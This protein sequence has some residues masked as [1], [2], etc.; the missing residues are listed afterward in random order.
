M[1][2]AVIKFISYKPASRDVAVAQT[3]L[4]PDWLIDRA[5]GSGQ[6]V[7]PRKVGIPPT[8]L[9]GHGYGVVKMKCSRV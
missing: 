4:L 5:L 1:F 3:G 9:A 6:P 7:K 8:F 2:P